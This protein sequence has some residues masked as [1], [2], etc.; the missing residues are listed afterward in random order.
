MLLTTLRTRLRQIAADEP[1]KS[2]AR[3]VI[4]DGITESDFAKAV[5]ATTDLPDTVK[6]K[7]INAYRDVARA[8]QP[9][10]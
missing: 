3:E 9:P 2:L 8:S 6:L 10:F 4:A 5:Y 7:A 1:Y